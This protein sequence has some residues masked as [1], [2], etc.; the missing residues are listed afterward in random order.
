MMDA[1]DLEGG[2]YDLRQLSYA[3][4]EL[5]ES[6]LKQSVAR[7]REAGFWHIHLNDD[8]L[9]GLLFIIGEVAAKAR[10]L[11]MAFQ[12]SLTAESS[13]PCA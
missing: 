3:C 1:N 12:N 10:S 4:R 9:N 11:D 8:E 5:A 2:L 13:T 7:P 6:K